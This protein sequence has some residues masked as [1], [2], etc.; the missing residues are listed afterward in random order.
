MLRPHKI[1]W[2]LHHWNY[3]YFPW[4]TGFSSSEWITELFDTPLWCTKHFWYNIAE[5]PRVPYF[6]FFTPFCWTA[7]PR[8]GAWPCCTPRYQYFKKILNQLHVIITSI[9]R[10][11]LSWSL[12]LTNIISVPSIG[13]CLGKIDMGFCNFNEASWKWSTGHINI[14]KI[15]FR[16][17]CYQK[18]QN[19]QHWIS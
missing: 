2:F 19:N 15:I 10:A 5:Q 16:V 18:L 14:F 9:T 13:H 8:C 11:K 1:W 3:L 7:C 4:N 17:Y 12:N 6:Q